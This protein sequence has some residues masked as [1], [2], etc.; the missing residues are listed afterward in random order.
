MSTRPQST[1][2]IAQDL[3]QDPQQEAILQGIR[4]RGQ[5]IAEEM[6]LQHKRETQRREAM[7]RPTPLPDGDTRAALADA[8]Q[9]RKSGEEDVAYAEAAHTRAQALLNETRDQLATARRKTAEAADTTAAALAQAIRDG[10]PGH[11]PAAADWDV[12]LALTEAEHKHSIAKKAADGLA[13]EL[14]AARSALKAV[15]LR[16][17]KE[18]SNVVSFEVMR[19]ANEFK[20]ALRSA[21]EARQ[22]AFGVGQRYPLSFEVQGTLSQTLES[23]SVY[24]PL[25]ERSGAKH[26]GAWQSFIAELQ[27][28]AAA[29]LNL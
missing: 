22:K 4:E 5:K 27:Q 2:T 25:N 18:I 21:F 1:T 7:T 13:G 15:E 9:A 6:H 28:D 16:V 8:L 29:E 14:A 26:Q 20:A 12:Q 23:F 17:E 11:V 10:E 3:L 19:L 24:Q